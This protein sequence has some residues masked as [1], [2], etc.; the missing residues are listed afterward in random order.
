MLLTWKLQAG[1][2]I[3]CNCKSLAQIV[4]RLLTSTVEGCRAGMC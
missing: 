2:D 3:R 4:L 1:P